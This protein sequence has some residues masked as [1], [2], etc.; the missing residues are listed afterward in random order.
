MPDT[1]LQTYLRLKDMEITTFRDL[2]GFC[3]ERSGGEH[4]AVR[5]C[6]GKKEIPARLTVHY[7]NGVAVIFARM[8]KPVAEPEPKPTRR[9]K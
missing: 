9:R 8:I 6:D 2:W 3:R 5:V 7:E 1:A 4:L